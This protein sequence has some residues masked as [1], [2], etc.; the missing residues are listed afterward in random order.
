MF[1]RKRKSRY[2]NAVPDWRKEIPQIVKMGNTQPV[3]PRKWREY[4]RLF[5][6]LA[7]G[8][9]MVFLIAGV[10]ERLA[11]G[12]DEEDGLL[13]PR[14]K[15]V[16][17]GALEEAW[18]RDFLEIREARASA[19]VIALRKKLESYPQ[20]RRARV[21]REG[22]NV[23]RIELQE[24]SAIARFRREDGRILNVGDDGVLFPAETYFASVQE[25]LPFVYDVEFAK[26]ESGF[27]VI[28]NADLLLDFLNVV[29][30]NYPEMRR[31]WESVS[32]KDLPRVLL[33]MHLSQPWA[34]LRVKPFPPDQADFPRVREIV[35]S[36]QNFRDELALLGSPDSIR[37]IREYFSRL[38]EES[39]KE[40]KIVFITNRKN[41]R[42]PI[43]EMR[44]IPVRETRNGGARMRNL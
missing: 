9:A 30:R 18:V 5:F 22:G 19:G 3:R 38:Q 26:S 42:R 21:V 32:A 16:T 27:D 29:R 44:I 17:N 23:L 31:T 2:G 1:F 43:L 40:Y 7:S 12:D 39:S 14:L 35:F 10:A 25:T 20:I 33:P 34:V 13:F 4:F 8:L 6:V 36:A 11:N 37:K 15:L 24:R 28:R 41:V